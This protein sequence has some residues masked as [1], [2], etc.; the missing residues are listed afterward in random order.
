MEDIK[1]IKEALELARSLIDMADTEEWNE[2]DSA[3]KICTEAVNKNAVLRSVSN[4]PSELKPVLAKIDH[5]NSLGKSTWYEVVYYDK[6]WR[7]YAGSD[8]F[9][10]GEKV[11]KWRYCKD[12]C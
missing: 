3:I 9:K 10:D 1:K 12:C 5:I 7:C 6:H 8:T 2:I 11:V 4:C